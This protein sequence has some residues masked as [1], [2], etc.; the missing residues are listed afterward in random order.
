MS[1][2]P[3]RFQHA[4][5]SSPQS[6]VRAMATRVAKLRVLRISV[7]S[8][9]TVTCHRISLLGPFNFLHSRRRCAKDWTGPRQLG[10]EMM[11]TELQS[12]IRGLAPVKNRECLGHDIDKCQ[13]TAYHDKGCRKTATHIRIGQAAQSIQSSCPYRTFFLRVHSPI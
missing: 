6:P 1:D 2:R 3:W 5:P 4:L 11:T 13:L 7:M 12:G 10:V 9:V 8:R